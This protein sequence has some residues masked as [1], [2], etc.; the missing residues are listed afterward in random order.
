M[1]YNSWDTLYQMRANLEVHEKY[2]D[3]FTAKRLKEKY[4]QK[5]ALAFEFYES[6]VQ[7]GKLRSYGILEQAAMTTDLD[8]RKMQ[9]MKGMR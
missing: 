5:L 2:K 9:L 4:F 1:I 7:E 6:Q 8:I 3:M